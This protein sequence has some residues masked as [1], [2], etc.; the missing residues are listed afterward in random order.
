MFHQASLFSR[1]LCGEEAAKPTKDDKTLSDAAVDQSLLTDDSTNPTSQQELSARGLIMIDHKLVSDTD[2]YDD[3]A[4]PDES[5][6]YSLR[7]F[8]ILRKKFH[9]F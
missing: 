7:Y 9:I 2:L 4:V 3:D 5:K 8:L 6:R 1:V